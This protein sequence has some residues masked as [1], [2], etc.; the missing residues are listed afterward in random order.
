MMPRVNTDAGD[1]HAVATASRTVQGCLTE[2]E[3]RSLGGDR[4]GE[5]LELM[6][7]FK[8]AVCVQAK[9]R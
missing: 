4:V 3:V 7:E 9:A 1:P 8:E 5:V 6:D 2:L